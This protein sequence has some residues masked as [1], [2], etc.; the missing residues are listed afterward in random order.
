M[1]VG[2]AP[3]SEDT[4]KVIKSCLN[5]KLLQAYGTSETAGAGC[6][7][8]PFDQSIGGIGPPLLGRIKLIDWKEGGYRPTDKP[9]PRGEIVIGSQSVSVGYFKLKT[10]TDEA[11]YTDPDGRQWFL[12]GDIGE[13]LPNGTFKIIDRKK[14]FNK[15]TIWRIRVFRKGMSSFKHIHSL[16]AFH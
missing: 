9:N 15:I 12:T 5:I 14:G 7:M 6:M 11:F 13:V 4:Q 8:D 2:G 10:A 1:I 16:M 3:L